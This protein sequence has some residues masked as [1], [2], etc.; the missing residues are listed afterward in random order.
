MPSRHGATVVL[1]LLAAACHSP[2]PPPPRP[3]GSLVEAAPA[4][5]PQ[6]VA[7]ADS[8]QFGVAPYMWFAGLKGNVT[9]GNDERINFS[10]PFSEVWNDLNYSVQG[11]VE[12]RHGDW[13][14][15]LDNTYLSLTSNQSVTVG[16]GLSFGADVDAAMWIGE[17]MGLR[18]MGHDSPYELGL[19]WRHLDLRVDTHIASLPGGHSD[20]TLNDGIVVARANWPL[21]DRWK[22][23]LYA[24]AG[25]GDS[26]FTWQSS[27]TFAYSWERWDV[28]LGYRYLDYDVGGDLDANVVIKGPIIGARYRF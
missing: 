25:A 9:V 12:A 7:D 23:N 14:V 22:F 13:A 26:D 20:D 19:G 8:W 5:A 3:P 21:A 4:T 10:M 28:G 15:V 18:R 17:L 2:P 6:A 16:P 24:D 1:L 11:V 27:A